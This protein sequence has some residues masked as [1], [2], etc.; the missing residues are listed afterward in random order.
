MPLQGSR[1]DRIVGSSASRVRSHVMW[2]LKTGNQ[3]AVNAYEFSQ[4]SDGHTFGTNRWR[5]C[6]G[7]LKD[8]KKL[9]EVL[10]EGKPLQVQSTFMLAVGGAVLYPVC[11]ANDSTTDVREMKVRTSQIRQEMFAAFGQLAPQVQTA[12]LISEGIDGQEWRFDELEDVPEDLP[13]QPKMVLLAYASNREGGLL[14]CY[15]GEATLDSSG[16]VKWDWIEP[17]PVAEAEGGTGGLVVTRP[18][19]PTTPGFGAG[20]EPRIDL[21]DADGTANESDE[22]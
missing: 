15:V 12:L 5:F 16:A 8:E 2:A 3:E 6:V 4:Y 10:P 13:D 14:K 11:Y 17:L 1:F 18:T 9:S 20:A 19:G 7:A 21:E 22:H